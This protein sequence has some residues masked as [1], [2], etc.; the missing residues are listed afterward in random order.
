MDVGSLIVVV[1]SELFGAGIKSI[2]NAEFPAVTSHILS[3]CHEAAYLVAEKAR[4][5]LTMLEFARSKIELDNDIETL[6]EHFP[7]AGLIVAAASGS[8]SDVIEHL[9]HGAHGVI[10]RDQP[11]EDIARAMKLVMEGGIYVPDVAPRAKIAVHF[12]APATQRH[13]LIEPGPV[14]T[15]VAALAAGA[16]TRALSLPE[17]T[18]LSKRQVTV[19]QLLVQGL[20]NKAIARELGLSEGTVKAHNNAVFRALK[21]TN[22]SSAMAKVLSGWAGTAPR[23]EPPEQH[24]GALAQFRPRRH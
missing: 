12:R 19:L 3:R 15:S 1:S 6:R 20:S 17:G 11:V 18:C 13:R 5:C 21:V 22:R 14:A 24:V 23:I 2:C 9:S 8:R 10:F 16:S 4:V 7:S